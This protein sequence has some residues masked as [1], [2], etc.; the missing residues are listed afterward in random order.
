M[1]HIPGL[2]GWHHALCLVHWPQHFLGLWSWILRTGLDVN[3]SCSS[4]PI[5]MSTSYNPCPAVQT[6]QPQ[7]S[8]AWW[9]GNWQTPSLRVSY[10]LSVLQT[11]SPSK[12]ITV[13]P[14]GDGFCTIF[15]V[16]CVEWTTLCLRVGEVGISG[17][18]KAPC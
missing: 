9:Q 7:C 8:D 5:L 1:S 18:L 10:L 13:C 14:M 11:F 6:L 15:E 3:T 12:V 2:F 4:P 16:S 17:R